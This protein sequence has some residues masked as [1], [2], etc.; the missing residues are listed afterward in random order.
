[1][2]I[3]GAPAV[4]R[5][6]KIDIH[7]R[8]GGGRWSLGQPTPALVANELDQ[9]GMSGSRSSSAHHGIG[10]IEGA[11]GRG[12]LWTEEIDDDLTDDDDRG[13]RRA[14]WCDFLPLTSV[15]GGPRSP[16]RILSME[17]E[18]GVF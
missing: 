9:P 17:P 5:R 8:D 4:D 2:T 18:R 14:A 10:Q 11:E 7:V 12:Q 13:R 1:M 16:R 15:L 6:H 3:E